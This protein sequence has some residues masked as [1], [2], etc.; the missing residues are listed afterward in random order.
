M[1]LVLTGILDCFLIGVESRLATLSIDY[2]DLEKLMDLKSRPDIPDSLKQGNMVEMAAGLPVLFNTLNVRRA[3]IPAANGH[4]TA[5]ALAR[6][7]AALATGGIVPPPHSNLSKPPLGS[8]THIPKFPSLKAQKKRR[9]MKE[10]IKRSTSSFALNGESKGY[11]LVDIKID[12]G[13]DNGGGSKAIRMF[14]NPEIRDAFMGTNEY[15]T[16]VFPDGLFGLGFRR[17][18]SD[19]G[20]VT[21]FGHSGVGGSTGFCNIEHDFSIAITVNKMS[22]GGLTRRIVQLVCS[23]LNVPVPDEFS[24]N[25]LKGPDMQA[26]RMN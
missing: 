21:S 26:F 19:G 1:L 5:R 25:G 15:G 8:H 16:L 22:L 3:I 10:L 17:F 7:Y 24:E 6:Y 4:T 14:S 23:E 18:R 9:G 12:D 11:A 13:D 20:K 2:D